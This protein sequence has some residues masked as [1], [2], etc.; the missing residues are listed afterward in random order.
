MNC[1]SQKRKIDVIRCLIEGNSIRSTS[2]ITGTAR[3]TITKILVNTG[4]SCKNYFDNKIRK[5]PC[6]RVQVDEIW[7]FVGCKDKSLKIGKIGYGSIWTWVALDPDTKLV[8]SFLVGQRNTNN[9]KQFMRDLAGRLTNRINLTSDGFT[10]YLEAVEDIFGGDLDFAMVVKEYSNNRYIGSKKEVLCG[11]PK[12]ISTSLVERQNLTMRMSIR[13]FT[14]KTNAF[15][16]KFENHQCAIAL[17]FVYYNFI[18]IHQTIKT[19]PAVM[20]GLIDKPL[21]LEDLLF[22]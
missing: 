13:R 18:R 19:T 9:A 22:L 1:L 20:A 3:E 10:P 21:E 14:R 2:R 12:D 8:I 16:K 17:H 11:K 7:S 15:S 6:R 4:E 5:L